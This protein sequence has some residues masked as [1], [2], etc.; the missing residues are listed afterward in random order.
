MVTSK[1]NKFPRLDRFEIAAGIVIV[2]VLISIGTTISAGD[3][4]G[5]AV[6]NISPQGT[7]H[8]T[9]TINITFGE[10]MDAASVA[11]HFIIQPHV[12]GK[13]TWS[14]PQLTFAPAHPLAGGQS[15]S[16]TLK[17]GAVSAQGR[18]LMDDSTW[19][20]N[21]GSPLVV[22]LWPASQGDSTAPSNLWVVDP[23]AP[24]TGTQLTFSKTGILPDY[25]VS[26][27]GTRVAFAQNNADGSADLY[28]LE[29][30]ELDTGVK[31]GS[32]QRLTQC[33]SAVCQMPDFSPDGTRIAYERIEQ[34]P[35][36]D[37]RDRG[38]PR[39]WILNLKDLS[40]T[41]L[42][43]SSELLGH[44]PHWS[45][46]GT[47]IAVHDQTLHA[48]AIYNLTNGDRKLIPSL[49]GDNGIFDP[50]GGRFVYPELAQTADGFFT[51]LSIADLAHPEN[52]T[53]SLS[54]NNGAQVDDGLA[55]WNPDG[56]QL[57]VTRQYLS[58]DTSNARQLYLIDPVTGDAQALTQDSNYTNGAIAWNPSGN[59]I[60]VQRF[61]V[62]DQNA[63]PG[64]WV[65]D[66]NAKTLRQIANNGYLP[67]W[68]P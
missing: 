21:V 53:H 19:R 63:Q 29:L 55:A 6:V 18:H 68:I 57:A 31:A 33:V 25:T 40:T 10:P 43:P 67:Q 3:R 5:V 49:V 42:L 13:I 65:Y 17:A 37:E 32:I 22:Y 26:T 16:V 23:A 15:Y 50:T 41:P 9:S 36:L 64:I 61:P 2:L 7:A 28:M 52:G 20:F 47:Q 59:Q 62:L 58:T 12:D 24:F 39:T 51:T 60:V 8:T 1:L 44:A 11:Q 27:D 66:L 4:A 45:P 35:Q 56:K 38:V 46:D 54:G 14:G 34:N 30:D 48:I